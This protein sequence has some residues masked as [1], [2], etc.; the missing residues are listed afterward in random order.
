MK[1]SG[2]D[3]RQ[4][5]FIYTILFIFASLIVFSGSFL[6]GKTLINTGDGW[7]QHYRALVYY[8]TYLKSIFKE[9][10][11]QHRLVIP[12]WDFCIGEGSDILRTM[13]YYA[14]GDPFSVFSVFVPTRFM[15]LYYDGMILLRMYL[16]GIA[17]SCLCF[18]TGQKNPNAVL[19]GS[20]TYVFSYWA[21]KGAMH[22]F[23]LTP[24]FYLPLLILGVE[25][26]LRKER[27]YL[28]IL[29]VF[30]SAISNL[31]FFYILVLLTIFYVAVRM[32][33]SY[34]KDLR[35][36]W[37]MF[38]RIA[39]ASVLGVLLSAVIFL[40]VIPAFLESSRMSAENAI[41]LFYP[42]SYYI[43]Y[44]SLFVTWEKT[45][46][47]LCLGFSVPALVAAFLLFY[48]R[49][50]QKLRILKVLFLL[51]VMMSLFPVFG[52]I[53]NGF[54][55]KV[56]R[57]SFAFALVSAYILTAVWPSLMNLKKKEGI[58]LLC[59]LSGYLIVCMLLQHLQDELKGSAATA[60]ICSAVVL[61]FLFLGLLLL[62]RDKK[63]ISRQK[64]WAALLLVFIS[65][66]NNNYW[67]NKVPEQN[68]NA[69]SNHREVASMTGLTSDEASVVQR[70][71]DMEGV[72]EFY[73]F[74]GDSL[75]PNANISSRVPSTQFYWSLSNSN[76][77][78]SRE[79]TELM[80][81][82]SQMYTG[83]DGRTGQTALAS[84]RYYVQ[85]A[86]I[87]APVPYGF[88]DVN[89]TVDGGWRIYRND[90]TLPLSYT[91][92]SC[93]TEEMWN[94]LS[95]IEKQEAMLKTCI[96][97]ENEEGIAPWTPEFASQDVDYK[98][99]CKG[100]GIQIKDNA[101]V[102]TSPKSAVKLKFSGL[103]DSE[104]YVSIRGLFYE[105]TT[106]YDLYSDDERIDPLNRYSGSDWD[107]L[108]ADEKKSI[109][110]N[111]ILKGKPASTYMT[112]KSS[113]GTVR[114]LDYDTEDANFYNNRHDFTVNLGYSEK[115]AK[116]IT[117]KFKNIGIYK[118]DSIHVACQPMKGYKEQIK[119]RKADT[120]ENLRLETNT[121][122]GSISLES[123]KLLCLSI[124][125]SE[126]WKAYVDGKK[127]TLSRANIQ[128]MAVAL[129]AGEHE[130]RLVYATPLL[131][132]GI[133]ISAAA[134][135]FFAVLIFLRERK[136]KH[137]SA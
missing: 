71:A 118:F 137:L 135:L 42:I 93:M 11:F 24:M 66:F 44:P 136:A 41:H 13:H 50:E 5:F 53:L 123:P 72:D 16:S 89:N 103:K 3:N 59:C 43:K 48:K 65:I 69:A 68:F 17:F 70:I 77:L 19:A 1:C 126:G 125:Y 87:S 85:P 37:Q 33:A 75:T 131:R 94:E 133:Y 88:T 108:S 23:F 115:A 122:T 2:K 26:I 73:R 128:Y 56:N 92:D 22:H 52:H 21:I 101:F 111:K 4:Y 117:I 96:L 6:S 120:L 55:Y 91:Y 83:Y 82:R 46:N 14:I 130:V 110:Q 15:Y 61:A 114:T 124:P 76:V 40:P 25:K 107:G 78:E 29:T 74:S 49:G 38:L 134:F 64:Q 95:A 62:L 127:T 60:N 63:D 67:H 32:I 7:N 121:V 98:L 20:M 79:A 104:T 36:A 99:I 30:F 105:G 100:D 47:W 102:V 54:S 8:S 129:D 80:E 35:L 109:L 90:D 31:Y 86:N 106:K 9:L 58:F 81:S 45:P 51:C 112:L 27:P 10:L 97:K 12:A 84:V 116:S 119:A 132:E 113:T 28:F 18:K 39:T 57:W 34:R